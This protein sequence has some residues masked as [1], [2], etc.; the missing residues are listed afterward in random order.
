MSCSRQCSQI[1][2]ISPADNS[3]QPA[4]FSPAD[5]D[6]ARPLAVCLHTWSADLTQRYDE[7]IKNC[8]L[9]NWHFIFPYFRGPNWTPEACGS[10]LVIADIE[11]AAAYVMENFNVDKSRVYLLGGSGGAHATMLMAGVKPELFTAYSA[12]CP[13]T[14]VK[15]WHD[16]S[17]A[18]N[19]N[20][21]DHIRK[22]CGGDPRTDPD[23][24]GEAQRRSP[25]TYLA[26]AKN[27]AVIDI[28]AGIHDGHTGS[29][30]VSHSI[31]AFNILAAET[32]RIS[33][34][35]IEYIVATEKIPPHLQFDSVD[36]AFADRPVLMRRTSG[37]VRLTIFDSGHDML[38]NA[39]F[40][41]LSRQIRGAEPVWDSGSI[42]SC[43]NTGIDS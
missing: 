34:A 25:L 16:E 11:A 8:E 21:D 30:P 27:N 7:Y 14:D 28:S 10:P 35:D 37:K 23:A 36:P 6:E 29:V 2:Y 31:R 33:E 39:A 40:G 24:A 17:M 3:P 13:I 5:G 41:F 9:L 1:H 38:Y 26:A 20:Y 32:D 19:N 4:I 18:R 43:Q 15:V 42:S 12:W 22:A